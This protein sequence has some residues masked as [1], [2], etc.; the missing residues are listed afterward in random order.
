MVL[1][2]SM[3]ANTVYLIEYLKHYLFFDNYLRF[4]ETSSEQHLIGLAPVIAT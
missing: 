3:E 2:I 1:E 4:K